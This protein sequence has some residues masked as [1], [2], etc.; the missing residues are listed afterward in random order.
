MGHTGI[1]CGL[2]NHCASAYRPVEAG[3]A[4]KLPRTAVC[5]AGSNLWGN[6]SPNKFRLLL[7]NSKVKTARL[8]GLFVPCSA[9]G[10]LWSDTYPDTSFVVL[11]AGS[12]VWGDVEVETMPELAKTATPKQAYIGYSD[13]FGAPL[14]AAEV[15]GEPCVYVGTAHQ[16]GHPLELED[17]DGNGHVDVSALKDDEHLESSVRGAQRFVQ[18]LPPTR[19][20]AE[21]L[22]QQHIVPGKIYRGVCHRPTATSVIGSLFNVVAPVFNA[23]SKTEAKKFFNE[24][25]GVLVCLGS[26]HSCFV[27]ADDTAVLPNDISLVELFWRE[28]RHQNHWGRFLQWEKGTWQL[29][30]H[31]GDSITWLEAPLLHYPKNS[32]V[33]FAHASLHRGSSKS[34][35]FTGT[36]YTNECDSAH[37]TATLFASKLTEQHTYLHTPTGRIAVVQHLPSWCIDLFQDTVSDLSAD[38]FHTTSTNDNSNTATIADVL[39][40][41]GDTPQFL[42]AK[43][44]AETPPLVANFV[45]DPET[46]LYQHM[47]RSGADDNEAVLFEDNDGVL[48]PVINDDGDLEKSQFAIA[49]TESEKKQFS[50]KL[51]LNDFGSTWW[52]PNLPDELNVDA[53]RANASD[54]YSGECDYKAGIAGIVY[55]RSMAWSTSRAS[56]SEL[57]SPK[58]A[59]NH[60]L[61]DAILPESMTPTVVARH[62]YGA[63]RVAAMQKELQMTGND[64]DFS[65]DVALEAL[66]TSCVSV[67]QDYTDANRK[68]QSTG[69]ALLRA[70]NEYTDP[71]APSALA[72]MVQYAYSKHAVLAIAAAHELKF[73]RDVAI[74]FAVARAAE[75][76]KVYTTFIPLVVTG[77]PEAAF[78]VL[79]L[80]PVPEFEPA[81]FD[82][83]VAKYAKKDFEESKVAEICDLYGPDEW[84]TGRGK[85]T[86]TMTDQSIQSVTCGVMRYAVR[87][88]GTKNITAYCGPKNYAED[89]DSDRDKQK[90]AA[91]TALVMLARCN[92]RLQNNCANNDVLE[93][94]DITLHR[95][96]G[97]VTDNANEKS[98]I[99]NAPEPDGSLIIHATY[100]KKAS[101]KMCVAVPYVNTPAHNHMD[102]AVIAAIAKQ[103]PKHTLT[104]TRSSSGLPLQLEA[105][106]DDEGVKIKTGDVKDPWLYEDLS[107]SSLLYTAVDED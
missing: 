14:F 94:G 9:N 50:E 6:E 77:V 84:E 1:Y 88:P 89:Y 29:A 97:V 13:E 52:E 25:N 28:T 37:A 78:S 54:L 11:P 51:L 4:K 19:T 87:V 27:S 20:A 71:R 17:G 79:E 45:K 70:L 3:L 48:E 92:Q 38:W 32:P 103:Y 40:N 23:A 91:L 53:E 96:T 74:D 16:H 41:T 58:T 80:A 69:R 66:L 63:A 67:E 2:A 24:Q 100:K 26:K 30:A 55:A 106:T 22:L 60:H 85:L 83:E 42:V 107:D 12:L 44:F 99:I 90:K 36:R 93:C 33:L 105:S 62:V 57:S 98:F 39:E 72:A 15:N 31:P 101:F 65:S 102:I 47:G 8:K 7:S 76:C 75:R 104:S 5:A 59:P 73:T 68:L 56:A 43:V 21:K 18:F 95:T 34:A 61:A 49:V 35:N 81:N 64:V 82:T 46:D 10:T 86:H